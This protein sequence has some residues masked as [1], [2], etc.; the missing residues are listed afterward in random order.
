[1]ALLPPT[2]DITKSYEE[3]LS[4]G[5]FYTGSLP[6]AAASPKTYSF[7]GFELASPIGVPAGPLLDAAYV[8]LY[9][10]LGWD[11]P[12]YKTVRSIARASHP[13]PNCLFIATDTL[14]EADAHSVRTVAPAPRSVADLTITNSFG[15]PS[16]APIDWQ[17]DVR[18]AS[19]AMRPGQL[20]VVSVVGTPGAEGRSLEDDF[21]HTAALAKAAGA[22]VIEANFSCPNVASAEGELFRDARTVRVHRPEDQAADRR[23]AADHQ[24]RRAAR[25]S[26]RRRGRGLPSLCRWHRGDQHRAALHRRRRRQSGPSRRWP[27]E[28]RRLRR[29]H[30]QG[31]HRNDRP[32]PAHPRSPQ[33][34]ICRRQRRRRDVGRATSTAASPWAPTSSWPPPP[35]CGIRCSPH[36]GRMARNKAGS[37]ALCHNR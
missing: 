17:V 28:K 14:S 31:R 23:H 5:P 9:A 3:N 22:R 4:A 11:V 29:R 26:S 30:R 2:Y 27:P 37:S 16:K 8:A 35:P 21:A 20:L 25:R 36:A 1:M 10:R 18:R 32:P 12:V 15:M 7:M 33:R 24:D 6:P 34:D 13:V 19:D